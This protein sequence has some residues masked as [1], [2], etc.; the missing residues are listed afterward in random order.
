MERCRENR[1]NSRANAKRDLAFVVRSTPTAANT[2]VHRELFR[3]LFTSAYA[4][5]GVVV[6]IPQVVIETS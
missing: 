5:I 4:L 2:W 3:A 1:L 6:V